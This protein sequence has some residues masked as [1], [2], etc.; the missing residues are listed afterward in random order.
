VDAILG[1]EGNGP[2][3]GGRPRFVGALLAGADPVM[4]DVACCRV[5]GADTSA[6]ET[7]AAAQQRGL[8]NGRAGE[9]ETLGVPLAGLFVRDF[10]MPD[11]YEGIGVGNA[12]LLQGFMR[13]L[14]RRFGRWPVPQVGRCTVCGAC[15]QACPADAITLDERAQVAK[16]DDSLCIRCYCC[17]EICPD[18]AID[19]EHSAM[20]RVLHRLRLV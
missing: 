6:V 9:V 12:G 16:V 18:A 4:V 5:V 14:L 11:S 3:T 15:E 2:G 19:L 7:L 13:R 17:H 20:G 10:V 1:M 8:W